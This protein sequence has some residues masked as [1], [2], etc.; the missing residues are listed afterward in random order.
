MTQ[1]LELNE[2]EMVDTNGGGIWAVAG[3][4]VVGIIVDEVVE[5]TTGSDIATHVGNGLKAAG[6]WISGN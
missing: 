1:F 5:R 4:F 6:E 2:A 3:A